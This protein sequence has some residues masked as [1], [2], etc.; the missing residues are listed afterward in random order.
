MIRLSDG[1][2][3]NPPSA[4]FD[5]AKVLNHKPRLIKS[6]ENIDPIKFASI[7]IFPSLLALWLYFD[8]TWPYWDGASHVID[9]VKY[10]K[11]FS[12][13][14]F[15]KIHWWKDFLTVN[16][17]YPPLLHCLYG[18]LRLFISNGIFVEKLMAV[19]YCFILSLSTYLISFRTFQSRLAAVLSVLIINSYPVVMQYSHST[20][21]DF[22]Y[23]SLVVLGLSTLLWWRDLSNWY[24]TFVLGLALGV[25]VSSKQVAS[26][27]LIFPCLFL[28]VDSFRR[29]DFQSFRQLLVAGLIACMFLSVWLIP[30]FKGIVAFTNRP[31]PFADNPGLMEVLKAN[32]IGYMIQLPEATSPILLVLLCCSLLLIP[33]MLADIR[34]SELGLVILS[35]AGVIFPLTISYNNPE[36]R[37]IFPVFLLFALFSGNLLRV[38]VKSRYP[39]ISVAGMIFA[40]SIAFQYLYFS[41]TPYP[42]TIPPVLSL[43]GER[44]SGKQNVEFAYLPDKHPTPEGDIWG[45]QWV[46]DKIRQSDGESASYLLIVP[47][48]PRFNVHTFNLIALLGDSNVQSTTLRT[49]TLNGDDIKFDDSKLKYFRW[50]LIKEQDDPER[51]QKHFAQEKPKDDSSSKALELQVKAIKNISKLYAFKLLKDGST[52][53]LYR[54]D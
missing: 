8:H 40:V 14:S 6:L 36:I 38:L 26:Y 17:C 30:N 48:E 52:I 7:A 37:Y 13:P 35:A 11:L 39:F 4:S 51:Y 47:N 20:Y 46:L 45:Q 2:E 22:A 15:L 23:L 9:S 10:Q 34:L 21:L 24:R 33:M 43:V 27:F 49:W 32:S 31:C 18:F 53:S 3:A 42:I 28:L 29:K 19:S 54:Q 16:Y 1:T 41:F 12:H 50:F 44:F 5:Q 25:A